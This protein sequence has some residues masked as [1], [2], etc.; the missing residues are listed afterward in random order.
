M[1]V[2]KIFA[3]NLRR[4]CLNFE[5]IAE[6]CR[7]ANI[8]RQQFNKYLAGQALPNKRTLNKIAQ[9]LKIEEE[10]LFRSQDKKTKTAFDPSGTIA[11]HNISSL[12]TI[13]D[14]YVPERLKGSNSSQNSI[15]PKGYY[16]CYM[17]LELYPGYAMRA[18]IKTSDKGAGYFFSRRTSYGSNS[19]PGQTILIGKHGGIILSD[20]SSSFLVGRNNHFPYEFSV[21]KINRN[22]DDREILKFGVALIHGADH[23]FSC[24]ICLE[25]LGPSLSAGKQAIKHIGVI[26]FDHRSISAT[27]KNHIESN[28]KESNQPQSITANDRENLLKALKLQFVNN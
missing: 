1:S 19:R 24:K 25:Y 21:L 12:G 20:E 4:E 28:W 16:N 17:P 26:P 6:V 2:Y 13:A 5:S 23:E 18:L 11:P 10:Q 15:L 27:V 7:D 9:A 3:E 14:H 22:L 8:N